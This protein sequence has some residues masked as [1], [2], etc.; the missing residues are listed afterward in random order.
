[1]RCGSGKAFGF[2]ALCCGQGIEASHR[3]AASLYDYAVKAVGYNPSDR[4][5]TLV[6]VGFSLG[7]VQLMAAAYAE[8]RHFDRLALTG[9]M[10]G[11]NERGCLGGQTQKLDGLAWTWFMPLA[12]FI[13][14]ST[15]GCSQK[16]GAPLEFTK[17]L[18]F[19]NLPY[20]QDG[21]LAIFEGLNRRLG[22]HDEQANYVASKRLP[23]ATALKFY[24]GCGHDTW[25]CSKASAASIVSDHLEFLTK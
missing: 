22:A 5:Q 25:A 2:Y 8:N 18:N 9:L 4:A 1:V 11:D 21:E 7:S 13:T 15:R 3:H 12:D 19:E 6:G 24:E 10:Y 23:G 20:A 17:L 16:E 14:Q